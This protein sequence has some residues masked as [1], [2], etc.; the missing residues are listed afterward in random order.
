MGDNYIIVKIILSIITLYYLIN[1]ISI[2]H[3]LSIVLVVS[4]WVL[5]NTKNKILMAN[6]L[7]I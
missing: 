7:V 3:V 5:C 6:N 4:L 1:N 2:P